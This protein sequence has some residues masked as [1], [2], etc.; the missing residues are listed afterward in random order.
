MNRFLANRVLAA[1]PESSR[2]AITSRLTRQVMSAWDPIRDENAP[3]T[4]VHFPIDGIISVVSLMEDGTIA[5]SY[6]VGRDGVA[7]A[8][9]LLGVGTLVQRF[10]CQVPG[11]FYWMDAREFA[12][13]A[14]ND[15]AITA[16]SL[17][18]LHC[19]F[20]LTAQAAACNLIHDLAARC[21]RWLL[22]VHD[23]VNS[24]EFE[25]THEIL[26]TMLG[27]H[28]PAVTLAAG[29]LQKAGLIR[30]SRGRI[31]VVDRPN[32]ERASCEC[33]RIIQNEFGR[34]L[35]PV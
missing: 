35:T 13:L 33:Y 19:A 8:E 25:L 12:D 15:P 3:I 10:M 11:E 23:R 34:L 30:Y 27:V 20:T 4:R 29:A 24:D 1:M 17:R 9:I 5:E 28:R 6:T 14:A 16:V 7:G 21:A 31:K 32:L 2:E 18:Y 26:A 22:T